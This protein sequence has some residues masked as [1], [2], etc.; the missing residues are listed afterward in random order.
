M[1]PQ[2]A[3]S[4]HQ[5]HICAGQPNEGGTCAEVPP[6][7]LWAGG[8]TPGRRRSVVGG[9]WL[10]NCGGAGRA[11]C[12]P[13]L[14]DSGVEAFVSELSG[15]EAPSVGM[16]NC[17]SLGL[18]WPRGEP[19]GGGTAYPD[20]PGWNRPDGNCP[21]RNCS[22]GL[23]T[24]GCRP[25]PGA[26]RWTCCGPGD[27]WVRACPEPYGKSGTCAHRCRSCFLRTPPS[28]AAALPVGVGG[29]LRRG[30]AR[31]VVCPSPPTGSSNPRRAHRHRIASSIPPGQGPARPF[32]TLAKRAW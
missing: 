4:A 11:L 30:A 2:S 15:G 29:G 12:R 26:G 21:C 1:C 7:V 19:F 27:R 8:G 9:R 22:V 16:F 6:S 31:P 17:G 14:N 28:G 3:L 25:F 10:G 23:A 13:L 20:R 32:S 5:F 24:V 18:N